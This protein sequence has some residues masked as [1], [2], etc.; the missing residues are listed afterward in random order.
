VNPK[1]IAFHQAAMHLAGIN[2]GASKTALRR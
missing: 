2:F 1:I